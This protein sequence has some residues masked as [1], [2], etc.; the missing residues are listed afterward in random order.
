MLTVLSVVGTRPE[1]IKMAPVLKELEKHPDRVNSLLCY[2]GQHRDMLAP[3][4]NLFNIQPDIELNTMRPGQSL[5]S[6]NAEILLRLEPVVKKIR[7]NWIVA[8]GDTTTVLAAA[9]VSYYCRTK[10]AHVE[11]GLRTRDKYQPWPEEINRTLADSIADRMFAPTQSS[12][13]AL[14]REGLDEAKI[15][16]TGN[17][18]VDA[19]NMISE[20]PIDLAEGPLAG[21][22]LERRLVLVTAHRRENVGVPLRNICL[23][24]QKLARQARDLNVYFVFCM[25]PNPDVRKIVLGKLENC[26]GVRLVEP[27]EYTI[28]VHLLKRSFLVLT[29]SGGLQEEAPSFGVPVLVMRDKTERP[30]GIE[31][32]IAR[33]VGTRTDDIVEETIGLL[34]NERSYTS[35]KCC[36]NPYGDGKA[37]KRI[38][39]A[40]LE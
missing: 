24:I 33:I 3:V 4:L 40:L 18:V 12:K 28:L 1:A 2:S 16:V 7:P 17:T 26:S 30:E 10:F 23:A 13:D 35:M 34:S 38:V 9:L 22:P 31:T 8:Q 27:L 36:G 5:S 25:H 32:G 21:I 11:A 14:L 37:A 39:A 19:L 29:D 15:T 6:L 20:V